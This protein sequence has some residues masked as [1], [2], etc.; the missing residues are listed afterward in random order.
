MEYLYGVLQIANVFLSVVAG[1]IALSMFKTSREHKELDAWKYLGIVLVLFAIEEILGALR[2]FRYWDPG[3]LTHVV[4]SVM[5]L[6]LAYALI[7][8]IQIMRCAR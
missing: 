2:S 3:F 6:L 8:Q 1:A 7:R 5:L 4:P